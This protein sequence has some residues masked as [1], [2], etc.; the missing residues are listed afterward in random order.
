MPAAVLLEYKKVRLW[1][2]N[3]IVEFDQTIP[4]KF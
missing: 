4:E 2:P 3:K 1:F